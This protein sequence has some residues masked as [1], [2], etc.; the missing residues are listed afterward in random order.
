MGWIPLVNQM[1]DQRG[2]EV[3]LIFENHHA[4][5]PDRKDKAHLTELI[6]RRHEGE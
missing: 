3:M 1:R 4:I 6:A 5:R 2:A